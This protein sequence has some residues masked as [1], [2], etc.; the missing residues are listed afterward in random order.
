MQCIPPT[1]Q[2]YRAQAN[3]MK[4]DMWQT[5]QKLYSLGKGSKKKKIQNVNFFQKGGGG[6]PQSL[7]FFQI[8]FWQNQNC[9]LCFFICFVGHGCF[10][11]VVGGG[12][13][14]GVVVVW[15]WCGCGGGGAKCRVL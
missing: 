6:R 11:V 5:K 4:T 7:H 9:D 1:D 14:G 8:V 10:L 15:W 12:S 13:G 2:K 3:V